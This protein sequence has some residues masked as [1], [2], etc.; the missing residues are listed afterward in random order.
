MLFL[1][2]VTSMPSPYTSLR[3]LFNLLRGIFHPVISPL[4]GRLSEHQTLSWAMGQ[5]FILLA[6]I[7]V[8][9]RLSLEY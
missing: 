8:L 5:I 9:K 7:A 3:R 6:A 2:P 4:I 1:P